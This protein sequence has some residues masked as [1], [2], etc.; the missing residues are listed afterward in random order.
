[1][2]GDLSQVDLPKGQTSGL[3]DAIVPMNGLESVACIEL[4]DVDVVRHPLVTRIVRAYEARDGG[5]AGRENH[6]IKGN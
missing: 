2:T 5:A 6:L 1:V 3:R 4:T